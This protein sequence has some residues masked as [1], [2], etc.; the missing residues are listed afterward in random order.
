M[1]KIIWLALLFIPTLAFAQE[2][3]A[4]SVVTTPKTGAPADASF[5]VLVASRTSRNATGQ[6]VWTCTYKVAATSKTITFRDGCPNKLKFEMTH[7]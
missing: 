2:N 7:R 3:A 4:S 5:G 6:I 1:N